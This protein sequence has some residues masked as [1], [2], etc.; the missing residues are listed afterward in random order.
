MIP[1]SIPGVFVTPQFKMFKWSIQRNSSLSG[2][3]LKGLRTPNFIRKEGGLMWG[4]HIWER[5]HGDGSTYIHIYR[6]LKKKSDPETNLRR[7]TNRLLG[8]QRFQSETP[9][10]PRTYFVQRD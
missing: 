9:N 10:S 4:T 1:M 8:F 7:C 2:M 6:Y 5:K 3:T